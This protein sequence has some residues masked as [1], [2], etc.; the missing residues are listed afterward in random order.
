MFGHHPRNAMDVP[1][2]GPR[3]YCDCINSLKEG[4]EK[5][6]ELAES[7]M[8]RSQADQKDKYDKRI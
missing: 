1:P 5:V 2:S 8:K 4:L 3:T 7:S 6:Y